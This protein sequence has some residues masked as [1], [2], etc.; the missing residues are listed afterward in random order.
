[1]SWYTDKLHKEGLWPQAK[2]ENTAPLPTTGEDAKSKSELVK[3]CAAQLNELTAD[4]DLFSV[5][6]A[7]EDLLA[8]F[9]ATVYE[10]KDQVQVFSQ[11]VQGIAGDGDI[12]LTSFECLLRKYEEVLNVLFGTADSWGDIFD[13]FTQDEEFL[14]DYKEQIRIYSGQVLNFG[15]AI[16]QAKCS[17]WQDRAELLGFLAE[18]ISRFET[19]VKSR[20]E[21]SKMQLE[22]QISMLMKRQ[23]LF[24]GFTDLLAGFQDFVRGF[25]DLKVQDAK[26]LQDL[27]EKL[28]NLVKNLEALI[29]S[30][31][32]L[33]DFSAHY[34][35]LQRDNTYRHR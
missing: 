35:S 17:T 2:Q 28:E 18:A 11:L 27:L 10:V 16:Q 22:L 20:S 33:Q 15:L 26:N 32:E 23:Q 6:P 24:K 19:F 34:K 14:L 21:I 4:P 1:M 25:K 29:K 31:K 30:R 13:N 5:A 3:N 7:D 9:T 8:N 12:F